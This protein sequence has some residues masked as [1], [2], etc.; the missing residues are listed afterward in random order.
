MES[1][2]GN[3]LIAFEKYSGWILWNLFLAFIPLALSYFL[4]RQ[5]TNSR[6]LIWWLAFILFIAF[7]PNALYPLTGI[8]HLIRSASSGYS[9]WITV[10]IFIP[11][12]LFAIFSGFEAYV[13]SVI[14]QGCYL[15]R[16]GKTQFILPAEMMIHL[17]SS[18]GLYCGRFRRFNS[19]DLIADYGGVFVS[20]FDD[21]TSKFPLALISIAFI[22]VSTAYWFIKKSTLKIIV[23]MNFY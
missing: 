2:L 12:H 23:K 15:Q 6:S 4:F 16:Q 5:R 8:I 3:A 21:L 1:I 9:V 20:I 11:L 17:L 18:I 10:L 14:N 22:V 13:I 19:W 7:L